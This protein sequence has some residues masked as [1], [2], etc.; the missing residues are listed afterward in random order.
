MKRL[1]L[2]FL[3]LVLSFSYVY[4]AKVSPV[5][6]DLSIARGASQEFTLNLVGSK[7]SY[8]QDLIIYPSD[9]FMSRTGSLSFDIRDS[10]I[11]A[12]KW[13]KIEKN[14]LSLLEDQSKDVKFKISIPSNAIP[15]EY[16]AVI[17]VEP[18]SFTK[19]IDKD[20]PIQL[21]MKSRVAI[22][23]IL[24]VPGR[25]YSKK[26][27]VSGVKVA[28]TDTLIKIASSFKNSGNIHL[29]VV[30][31]ATIKSG[32]GKINFGK[33]E[34]SAISSPQRAAFIFPDAIRDFEGVLHRQLPAGEYLADVSYDYGYAFNKAHQTLKF[35]ITRKNLLKEDKAQFL[36]LNT[37]DLRLHIPKGGRRTQVI[38]VTNI[39][40]RPLNIQIESEEWLKINPDNIV[41]KSGEVRNLL[42]NISVPEYDESQTKEAIICFKTDR[43]LSSEMKVFVTGLK[44]NLEKKVEVKKVLSNNSKK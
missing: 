22:V 6:F 25:T 21:E 31:D 10:K 19:A 11:S 35:T 7:G 40:Y 13:I 20:K 42:L 14:K 27:E 41:L 16:Y 17:M 15:G 39:D 33:F 32:D 1:K 12:V 26:G 30:A 5:R 38:T 24:E 9:L 18:T 3:A 28:E 36:S 2:L 37:K 8:N 44:E 23:I 4:G 29:D 34:L 43:G